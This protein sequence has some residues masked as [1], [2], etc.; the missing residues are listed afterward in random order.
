METTVKFFGFG[1]LGLEGVGGVQ[2][3]SVCWPSL[4]LRRC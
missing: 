4:G 2:V 3:S 1:G